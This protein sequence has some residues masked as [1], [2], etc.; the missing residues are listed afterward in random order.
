MKQFY[1]IHELAKLFN[2]CPDTLRYYEEKGL[3]HPV[4]GEN[5]YRRYGIQDICTL[6]VIR[7]LRDLG[8]GLY[9]LGSGGAVGRGYLRVETIRVT[10]PDGRSGVLRFDGQRRCTVEDAEGVLRDLC[11][12][13]EEGER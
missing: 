13:R 4:R 9:N 8:L 10:M 2:L 12:R 3:L 1:Q 11:S 5:R 6:N 7:S